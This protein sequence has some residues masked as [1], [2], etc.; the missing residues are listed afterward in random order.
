MALA[1]GNRQQARPSLSWSGPSSPSITLIWSLGKP[2]SR[3][4]VTGMST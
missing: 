4:T 2:L 3:L 1:L